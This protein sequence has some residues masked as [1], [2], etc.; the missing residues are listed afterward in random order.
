MGTNSAPVGGS[1]RAAPDHAPSVAA[2]DGSRFGDPITAE[3]RTTG[4]T[5][6]EPLWDAAGFIAF[7]EGLATDDA[8][9][10]FAIAVEYGCRHDGYIAAYGMAFDDHAEVVSRSGDFRALVVEPG[11]ALRYFEEGNGTKTHLLWLTGEPGASPRP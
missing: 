8:P 3:P 7:L 5:D 6:P 4:A 2:R 1:L 9:R 10:L 11:S